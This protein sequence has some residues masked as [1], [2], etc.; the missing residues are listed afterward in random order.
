MLS[1]TYKVLTTTE[2]S[3]L[4]DLIS[5]QPLRS[6]RSSDIVTLARPPSYSSLKVNNCSLCHATPRLWNELPKELC[7]PVDDESISNIL[8]EL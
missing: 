3:Y 6:T 7:Q 5:R 1:L 8:M 2:P 4:Y